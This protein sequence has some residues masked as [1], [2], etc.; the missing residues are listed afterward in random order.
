MPKLIIQNAKISM[1]KM[2][3]MLESLRSDNSNM[4]LTKRAIRYE[5]TYP[6]YRKALAY[7]ISL[8][9]LKYLRIKESS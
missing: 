2:N 5:R 8:F 4:P 3:I 9:V 6:N 7:L 1:L